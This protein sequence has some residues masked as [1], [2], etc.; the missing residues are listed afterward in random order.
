MKVRSW[1][2]NIF[3]FKASSGLRSCVH[4]QYDETFRIKALY[5]VTMK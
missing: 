2:D 4:S 5:A 3:R 1:F